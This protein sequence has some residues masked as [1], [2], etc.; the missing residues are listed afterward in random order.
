VK[1]STNWT[2]DWL[3]TWRPSLILSFSCKWVREHARLCCLIYITM[4]CISLF[5]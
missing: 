3:L 4:D 1:R 5:A 2:G